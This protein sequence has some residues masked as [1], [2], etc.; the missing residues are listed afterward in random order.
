MRHIQERHDNL[1]RE[2]TYMRHMHSVQTQKLD[3]LLKQDQELTLAARKRSHSSSD[4]SSDNDS[5][6]RSPKQAKFSIGFLSQSSKNQIAAEPIKTEPKQSAAL[7]T[8][9]FTPT[10]PT[11]YAGLS[12][13]TAIY[14]FL[15]HQVF[16]RANHMSIFSIL[17]F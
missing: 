4:E 3:V 5:G 13:P 7:P 10:N 1:V 2:N 16:I 15:P 9:S 17:S 8:Q 12:N 14:G 6:I 11:P